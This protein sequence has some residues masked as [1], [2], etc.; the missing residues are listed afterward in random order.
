MPEPFKSFPN[1]IRP[2][3]RF[4]SWF[5]GQFPDTVLIAMSVLACGLFLIGSLYVIGHL[6]PKDPVVDKAVIYHDGFKQATDTQ[7]VQS[8]AYASEY[9]VYSPAQSH[10][11][12]QNFQFPQ[13]VY[14]HHHGST[15]GHFQQYNQ[16]LSYNEPLVEHEEMQPVHSSR[17]SPYASH[18]FGRPRSDSSLSHSDEDSEKTF[19]YFNSGRANAYEY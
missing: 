9:Q 10:A 4:F 5:F 19:D 17:L 14:H 3:L 16:H 15:Y 18:R 13:Q 12:S 1:P 2:V 11:P 8:H 7:H 6:S